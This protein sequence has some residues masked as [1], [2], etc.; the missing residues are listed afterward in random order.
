VFSFLEG[1][2]GVSGVVARRARLGRDDAGAVRPLFE[3]G[4]SLTVD[5][6]G[7]LLAVGQRADLSQLP[8]GVPCDSGLIAVNGDGAT[9]ARH[10]FAG[11]DAASNQ[12]TV[13]HAIG[14][15]T[16]A[17][18]SIH[19]ALSGSKAAAD[20]EPGAWALPAPG[21][22]VGFSEINVHYF[23]RVRRARRRQRPPDQRLRSFVETAGGFDEETAA[24]EMARCFTCGRCV[25]CDN[26]FIFC[27]D[28]AVSRVDGG[29]RI[30]TDHCKGCGLCI[31][32]CPRGSLHMVSER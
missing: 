24:A 9:S 19:A 20:P 11:G 16:R 26:C 30:S 14:A 12:R 6:D 5:T 10:V 1:S 2:G 25:G 21:H 22:V 8:A 28:M 13:T 4:S 23:R 29:Y 27:P 32:E 17:A 31:E 15:G 18:R 3:P 7:V